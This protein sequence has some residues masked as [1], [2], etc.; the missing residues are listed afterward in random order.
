[1]ILF[2]LCLI[3]VLGVGNHYN[4]NRLEL[5][6]PLDTQDHGEDAGEDV[7]EFIFYIQNNSVMED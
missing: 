6:I 5:N 3:I 1:M 7:K 4:K 2:I